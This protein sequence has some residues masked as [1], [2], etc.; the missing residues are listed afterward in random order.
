MLVLI[1]YIHTQ[2][3]YTE[4]H[5]KL[6]SKPCILFPGRGEI[7]EEPACRPE[8]VE[9]RVKCTESV[10][11]D[12]EFIFDEP[13]EQKTQLQNKFNLECVIPNI[14]ATSSTLSQPLTWFSYKQ[15]RIPLLDLCSYYIQRPAAFN[16]DTRIGIVKASTET[17][18]N[19]TYW[20]F[21]AEKMR[22]LYFLED[23]TDLSH[24]KTI[25]GLLCEYL[26]L[27]KIEEALQNII[28]LSPYPSG[29]L[30]TSLPVL[31]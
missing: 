16:L 31:C 21:R 20:A 23:P 24:M 22:K 17:I 18:G 9:R 19:F 28:E 12:S 1:F 26:A 30:A 4:A 5:S 11:E 6:I 7:N 10:H 3:Y 8:L 29:T 27:K 15:Q 13:R 14:A 2:A 25:N